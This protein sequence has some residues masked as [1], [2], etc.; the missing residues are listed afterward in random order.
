MYLP[1][2]ERANNDNRQISR[3]YQKETGSDKVKRAAC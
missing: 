1:Y 3:K 2:Y